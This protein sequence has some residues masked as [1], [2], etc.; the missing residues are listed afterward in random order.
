[1]EQINRIPMIGNII[2]EN[3]EHHNEN[4]EDVENLPHIKE[5]YKNLDDPHVQ[6]EFEMLLFSLEKMGYKQK[7]IFRSYIVFRYK[8]I[9]DAVEL[10]SKN[11]NIW[12]HRY[13]EGSK[14][15]CFICDD[16]EKNHI[17]FSKNVISSNYDDVYEF[18][19]RKESLRHINIGSEKINEAIKRMKSYNSNVGHSNEVS[20]ELENDAICPICIL[21]LEENNKIILG[22]KHKFCKDCIV[23]YLEEEIKNSRVD[24]IK[25]PEKSCYTSKNKNHERTNG[26]LIQLDNDKINS[27]DQNKNFFKF[28]DE[29]IQS[30]VSK[31]IFDKY[32]EFKQKIIVEK[33][34]NLTFCPIPNCKGFARIDVVNIKKNT[35]SNS[36]KNLI[37]VNKNGH[38]K[39]ENFIKEIDIDDDNKR[40]LDDKESNLRKHLLDSD[41]ILNVSNESQGNFKLTCNFNHDFC[42]RC[43]NEWKDNHNCEKD[44][45]LIKY[46]NENQNKLKKCPNC[47][48]WIEKNRGCNHMTCFMCKYEF[49]WLCMQECPPDH[50][51]IPG[52]D[53]YGKQFPD[54]EID[55]MFREAIND[56]RNATSFFFVF[57]LSFFA[58]YYFHNAYFQNNRQEQA[59]N[60]IVVAREDQRRSKCGFF[61][62]M[63]FVLFVFWFIMLFLNGVLLFSMLKCLTSLSP[64]AIPN[65]AVYNR[66]KNNA[67]CLIVGANLILWIIFFL[68]GLFITTFW[69]AISIFYL[70]WLLITR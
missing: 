64:V 69:F 4:E 46:S 66:I 34:K 13:I 1:M 58:L 39:N 43:K 7:L 30:L 63:V 6:K 24:P 51:N 70:I 31:Q 44:S 65:Q 20:L 35:I 45:E 15:K 5:F 49:C 38:R 55:P 32:L 27:H 61:T 21:E 14:S 36:N 23:N 68:P 50:Y 53:C 9:A 22:C 29:L 57:R 40:L 10:L 19:D 60:E 37:D 3:K 59:E 67:S 62:L 26:D 56:L 2:R 48:S 52:T 11:N 33:D 42:F 47:K 16:L 25:C 28:S 12:K 41:T 8:D 18:I 54:E 17:G